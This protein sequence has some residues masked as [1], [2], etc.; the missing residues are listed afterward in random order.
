VDQHWAV[1]RDND[2]HVAGAV[3]LAADRLA[4]RR[5]LT[6]VVL[7]VAAA[8]ALCVGLAV[9]FATAAHGMRTVFV[10]NSGSGGGIESITPFSVNSDGSLVPSPVVAVGDRPEGTAVTPDARFLYVATS[11][12]AGVR[13]YAIGSG[14]ALTE[15]PGSPFASGGINTT[16]VAVTPSG[17]RLLVTN[18]GSGAGSVAVYDINQA[19]GAL[20][21][22]AGSPFAVAGLEDPSGVAIAPGGVRA[23]VAGDVAGAT[24]DPVVAGLK[25]NQ[26]TGA[27][28]QVAGSPFASGGKNSFPAVISPDGGRLF[29]GNV[30]GGSPTISVLDVNQA[31]GALMPVAG[32]PFAAVG[33][34]PIG[35]ALSPDGT[36]LFS[37]ERDAGAGG[38]V[39]VYDIAGNGTLTAIAGSPFTSGGGR[40]EAVAT[41]PDGQ[42][43]YGFANANP[44][45]VEGFSIG[46][47]GALAALTG[48]PYPTGDKF[49]GFLSIAMTPSQTPRPAFVVSS[50]GGGQASSFDA[51]A[52]TTVPGGR[53]TR[54]DWSFG[55]GTTL[56][57]GG[58]TPQ[59]T[60][61]SPGTYTV[62]LT[63]TNDCSDAASFVG[64]TVF[65]GQTAHC[66]G[67][68]QATA[69]RTLDTVLGLSGP[70]ITLKGK[71][72]QKR[73]KLVKVKVT[74]DEAATVAGTGTIKVPVVKGSA[75]VAKKKKSKLK[76]RTKDAAPGETVTLKL[77]LR[78]QAK[79][80]TKKAQRKGKKPKAKVKVT[81]TDAAGNKSSA[82]RKIKLKKK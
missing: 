3:G 68:P 54:F 25:I 75:T 64:D 53:A 15:V 55:D 2:D 21:P 40:T 11:Q 80:L 5:R 58:A 39:S 44:S 32:S 72:T 43:V 70:T 81:A 46:A 78:K 24:F 18:R 33:R 7:A 6:L 67:S 26:T 56:P 36:R 20:T 71:K 8:L 14:G 62:G 65:T 52:A 23:F 41:T 37:A 74:V 12:T 47:A 38:G 34:A 79:K 29:I 31:T 48:S 59:H 77:K 61:S 4:P 30:Q 1:R 28:N 76:G 42:R 57:N 35:L 27:L 50:V 22:V 10:S 17:N 82:K 73:S 9:T 16:G 49:A 69:T 19:T 63:V 13:G 60:Y 51:S 66:N 45:V